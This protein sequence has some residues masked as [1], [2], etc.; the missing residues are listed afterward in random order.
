MNRKQLEITLTQNISTFKNP[1]SELEQYQTPAR[2]AA[3]LL[4]FAYSRD[5]LDDKQV[6]DACAGTGILGLGAALLGAE[7]VLID[8]DPSATAQITENAQRMDLDVEIIT[9]DLFSYDFHDRFDTI[10]INPPFGIQ[11][12]HHRDLDFI[13]KIAGNTDELYSIHD[14]SPAN[15][16]MLPSLLREIGL[17]PQ[18]YYLDEFPLE[19]T[20]Q[21]HQAL[22]K[23]HQVM[24]VYSTTLF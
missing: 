16:E 22:R 2:V 3:N 4:H 1:K 13:N 12:K 23:I 18:G 21:W 6:L 20:Y 17:D 11:Q 24:V 7:V 8:I 14:G 9:A 10:L 15:Q 5:S 19:N